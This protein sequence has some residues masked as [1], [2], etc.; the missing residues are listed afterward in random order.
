MID[1]LSFEVAPATVTGLL[2]PSGCG[3]S[4]LMRAIVGT[5]ANVDGTLDV[6]GRPAGSKQLRSRVGYV[7]QN[8]SVYGDLTARQNLDYYAAVLASPAANGPSRSPGPSATSTCSHT[9]TPSR[10]T[11]PAASTPASPS[12]S[13]SSAHPNCSSSTNPPSAWTPF[14]A[15]TCGTSST[16]SQANGAP[17]S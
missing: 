8:P 3:K 13:R 11:S 6:L 12:R 7:T 4:T 14:S 2:G 1:D 17:P 9:P 5:Q 16:A 10:E 15:A